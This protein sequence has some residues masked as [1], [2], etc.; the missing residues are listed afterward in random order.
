[1]N[2]VILHVYPFAYSTLTMKLKPAEVR[3]LSLTWRK[4]WKTLIRWPFEY[5]SWTKILTGCINRK[6][7]WQ[8]LFTLVHPFAILVACL[9]LFGLVVYS[10]S[11]RYKEI[12]IRKSTG[13]RAKRILSFT[14]KIMFCDCC[15][16]HHAIRSVICGK[17][18]ASKIW[19][20]DS[21]TPMPFIKSTLLIAGI[22][23]S[24]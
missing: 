21:V 1:M 16:I 12:S 23:L 19:P 5:R 7:S 18:M 20:P 11:Q 13:S 14:V 8:L 9:G 3:L 6:K 24:R 2:P 15:C 17:W 4:T 22:S 10:T